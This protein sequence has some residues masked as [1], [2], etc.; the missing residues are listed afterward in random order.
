MGLDGCPL[1]GRCCRPV[2]VHETRTPR[3]AYFRRNGRGFG[4]FTKILSG[5]A[6]LFLYS[7]MWRS[8]GDPNKVS[9]Y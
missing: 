8:Q 3:I 5:E 4:R 2:S 1:T 7:R 6:L 9:A